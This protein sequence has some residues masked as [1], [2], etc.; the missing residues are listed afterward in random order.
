[1]KK[2]FL[3]PCM[4]M[5]LS[6]GSSMVSM[7]ATGWSQENGVWVYYNNNG[8]KATDV[9]K[10]SGNRWFYLNN[11]VEMATDKPSS[12]LMKMGT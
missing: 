2:L 3:V 6:V 8:E 12:F 4:V 9:L 10:K 1:M 11:E 5:V 7:A